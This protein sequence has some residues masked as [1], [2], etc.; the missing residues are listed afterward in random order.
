[1]QYALGIFGIDPD[2]LRLSLSRCKKPATEQA[3]CEN[4]FHL[5]FRLVIL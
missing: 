4:S 2:G 3:E 1:M 5:S